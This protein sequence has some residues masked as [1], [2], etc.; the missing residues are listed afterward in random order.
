METINSILR[1]INPVLR[2]QINRSR[3]VRNEHDRDGRLKCKNEQL[4]MIYSFVLNI[5]RIESTTRCFIRM[6]TALSH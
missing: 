5:R 4:R 2:E 6:N 3:R 1:T